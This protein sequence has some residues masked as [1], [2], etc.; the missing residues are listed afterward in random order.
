MTLSEMKNG[1]QA[2]IVALDV[3]G[4]DTGLLI[5]LTAMGFVAGSAVEVI[6]RAPL[7]R[8]IQLKLRGSDL[9]LTPSL[10]SRVKVA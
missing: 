3:S 6:R 2:N 9:C 8:G 5:K 4:L 10:A 1:Q 7:G